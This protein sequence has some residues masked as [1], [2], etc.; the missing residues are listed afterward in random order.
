MSVVESPVLP[1]YTDTETGQPSPGR[2]ESI[3]DLEGVALPVT[4]LAPLG[5][6][7]R[8]CFEITRTQVVEHQVALSEMTLGEFLLDA[9]LS[10]E[11]PV[12]RLMDVVFVHAVEVQQLR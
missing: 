4:A 2:N 11:Q 10:R 5:Q 12:H 8:L 9:A 1:S 3:V 7:A 6:R